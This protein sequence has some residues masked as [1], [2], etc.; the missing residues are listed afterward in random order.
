MSD[1]VQHSVDTIDCEGQLVIIKFKKVNV[2]IKKQVSLYYAPSVLL[3]FLLF[4]IY[5]PIIDQSTEMFELANPSI[6]QMR[7]FAFSEIP[8]VDFMSS[9]M[10]SEQ[11][12]GLLYNFIFGRLELGI[13]SV[14]K[15][16]FTS[17]SW[18]L[19]LVKTAISF[20]SQ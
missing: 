12:Y 10:F 7:I 11:F 16:L 9:H 5:H 14:S 17:K 15:A 4:T 2:S 3:T 13:F 6:S 8:F 19:N 18:I 1:W 20:Q